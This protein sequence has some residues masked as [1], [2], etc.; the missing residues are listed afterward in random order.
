MAPPPPFDLT[1][2][3][4]DIVLVVC[5][6]EAS[7]QLEPWMQRGGFS[8]V[9]RTPDELSVVCEASLVPAGVSSEGPFAAFMVEGPLDFALTGIVARLSLALADAGVPVFVISTFDTDYVLVRLDRAAE[10]AAAWQHA[11][12]AVR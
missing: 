5:R 1:L 10:A 11:G 12:I 9:T 4:L 3:R 6:A 7:G 8:S 2:H